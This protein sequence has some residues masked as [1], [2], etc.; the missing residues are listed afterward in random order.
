MIIQRTWTYSLSIPGPTPS[1]HNPERGLCWPTR[2][3]HIQLLRS[4][5]CYPI[6]DPD[7]CIHNGN[8]RWVDDNDTPEGACLS[9]YHPRFLDTSPPFHP[10][11]GRLHVVDEIR[12]RIFSH[13]ASISSHIPDTVARIRALTALAWEGLDVLAAAE[14]AGDTQ[15]TKRGL[16]SAAA[17]LYDHREGLH[18]TMQTLRTLTD[19]ISPPMREAIREW[20]NTNPGWSH[21][22]HTVSEAGECADRVMRAYME[23]YG[24]GYENPTL[25]GLRTRQ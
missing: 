3:V 9:K 16:A 14:R 7:R 1:A 25:G 17:L 5:D 13:I 10:V 4:L 2:I 19:V 21:I 23:M 24:E 18:K 6:G 22:L 15:A 12:R 8:C 11:L 20:G